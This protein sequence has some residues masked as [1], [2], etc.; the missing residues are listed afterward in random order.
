MQ[1]RLDDY[2]NEKV[3]TLTP[4]EYPDIHYDHVGY[5]LRSTSS[6]STFYGKKN[7]LRRTRKPYF[8]LA[9]H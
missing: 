5:I 4:T 2:A 1:S 6:L 8:S 7:E 3:P 9:E